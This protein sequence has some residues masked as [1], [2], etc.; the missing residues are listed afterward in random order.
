MFMFHRPFHDVAEAKKTH[1]RNVIVPSVI[2]IY[3]HKT[4]TNMEVNAFTPGVSHRTR[5]LSDVFYSL[6]KMSLARLHP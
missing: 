2:N 5:D 3:K 6:F 1:S 4:V